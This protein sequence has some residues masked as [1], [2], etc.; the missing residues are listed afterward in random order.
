MSGPVSRT[1][2]VEAARHWLGTPYHHQASLR[3]V[4]CDCLGLVRG[5]WRDLY[6]PEPEAPPPYSPSWAESLGEETLAVAASRHLLPLPR[7][8][9]RAGDVVLFRWRG[10]LP[11]KHCAILTAHDRILHAHDGA[12]VSEVAFT[13][14]WRRHLSHAFSFP[15]VTD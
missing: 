13:S 7:E 14:W 2:I 12:Q 4:G 9:V 3:G 5:V 6:G 1:D 8:E 11:A 10:H 15:E